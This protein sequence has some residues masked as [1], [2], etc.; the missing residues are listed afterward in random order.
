MSV[1]IANN[2]DTDDKVIYYILAGAFSS[3][4]LAFVL[5]GC[6]LICRRSKN[7]FE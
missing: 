6:V 3:L 7:K 5:V 4:I 2:Y 1:D